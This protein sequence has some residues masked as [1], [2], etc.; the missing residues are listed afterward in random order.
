MSC[1]IMSSFYVL[2]VLILDF[3]SVSCLINKSPSVLAKR[4][5]CETRYVPPF[6][7]TFVAYPTASSALFPP[8]CVCFKSWAQSILDCCWCLSRCYWCSVLIF[9]YVSRPLDGNNM[10]CTICYLDRSSPSTVDLMC[11]PCIHFDTFS[12]LSVVPCEIGISMS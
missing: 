9:P 1:G 7:T 6:T 3:V 4:V 12:N 10:I 5:L 8:S 2:L 11:T